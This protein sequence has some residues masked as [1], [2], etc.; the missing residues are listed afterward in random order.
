[1]GSLE[2]RMRGCLVGVRAEP[3]AAGADEW[4]ALEAYLVQR[5]AGMAWEGVALRP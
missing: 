4:K 2:R 3:F 1:M 5:A